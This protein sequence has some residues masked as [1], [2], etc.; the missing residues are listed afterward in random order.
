[1]DTLLPGGV[2][3][4]LLRNH[5]GRCVSDAKVHVM[6][7]SVPDQGVRHP[8]TRPFKSIGNT[9]FKWTTEIKPVMCFAQKSKLMSQSD[10]SDSLRDRG[11]AL[12]MYLPFVVWPKA[13]AELGRAER[14]LW[15]LPMDTPIFLLTVL[16]A[17]PPQ[18]QAPLLPPDW[19]VVALTDDSRR[20]CTWPQPVT[21]IKRP[22][23]QFW[24]GPQC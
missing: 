4:L 14:L 20:H 21:A 24:P 19:K 11:S 10:V 12:Q 7:H 16:T 2:G 17:H 13:L 5:M 22:D 15:V 23:S 6:V 9:H 3:A 8:R 18:R 1:M